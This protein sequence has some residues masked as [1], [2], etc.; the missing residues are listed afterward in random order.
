[1]PNSPTAP[2]IVSILGCGWLGL[3]LLRALVATGHQVRGSSRNPETLGEIEA[4]GGTAFFIDLPGE[5]PPAFLMDCQTLIITLPPRGR[6]LGENALPHYLKCLSTLSP[7]LNDTNGAHRVIFCSSTGVYGDIEGVISES[8]VLNPNT[9]SAGAVAAAEHFLNDCYAGNDILRLAGLAGPGR[10]P[11]RFYGGRD[12]KI[13][14][15]DAPVNL[16]HLDDVIAA[17]KIVLEQNDPDVYNVCSAAHPTKGTFYTAASKSL[18]LEVAG[19]DPGGGDG[20]R[21]DSSKLRSLGWL[22]AWD[23][24]ALEYLLD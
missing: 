9:T 10:H 2:R 8:E 18:G 24:L 17:I 22:P 3:P 4:A 16:V 5:L 11:G 13:P 19:I 1:M 20:K 14:Q 12:R 23:D 6:A 15:A 7:W 21:I